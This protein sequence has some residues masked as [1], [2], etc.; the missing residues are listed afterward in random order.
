M[1]VVLF[2]TCSHMIIK[3]Q[4]VDP[5]IEGGARILIKETSIKVIEMC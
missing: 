1:D 3:I 5:L 4:K 2:K